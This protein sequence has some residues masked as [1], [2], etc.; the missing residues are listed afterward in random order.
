MFDVTNVDVRDL[1]EAEA[2]ISIGRP[3]TDNEKHLINNAGII[4]KPIGVKY[5]YSEFDSDN[6][7]GFVGAPNGKGFADIATP[8]EGGQFAS[9]F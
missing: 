7:F 9:I 2:L 8:T 5:V 3:L 6:P 4:P 1:G